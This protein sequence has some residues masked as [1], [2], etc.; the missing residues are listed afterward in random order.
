MFF[1]VFFFFFVAFLFSYLFSSY[2]LRFFSFFFNFFFKIIAWE[3]SRASRYMQLWCNCECSCTSS[4][5]LSKPL[6]VSG[7]LVRHQPVSSHEPVSSQSHEPVS[8]HSLS[9]WQEIGKRAFFL[10]YCRQSWS[11]EVW[12][13]EKGS[14]RSVPCLRQ[15][16]FTRG[17]TIVTEC[18]CRLKM[19]TKCSQS[20]GRSLT[21]HFWN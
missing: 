10:E 6:Y 4:C 2:F 16:G 11:K 21:K 7:L 8:S 20:G 17:A 14:R 18:E 13:G 3:R 1:F 9:L 5:L 12:K 19:E 15:A